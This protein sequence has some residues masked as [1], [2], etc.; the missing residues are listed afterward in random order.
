ML[1]TVDTPAIS[2]YNYKFDEIENVTSVSRKRDTPYVLDVKPFYTLLT[3]SMTNVAIIVKN[4]V[5]EI[6]N[7]PDNWDGC[8]AVAPYPQ[9]IKNSYKFID[10]LLSLGI[11]NIDSEDIYPMPY[12]SIVFEVNNNKG[13]VSIEIGKH[14]IGFFTDFVEHENLFSNGEETDFRSIPENL[15]KALRIL[16]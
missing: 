16:R 2:N 3:Q 11:S 10:A 12:G 9:V 5:S 8:N 14:S 4:R 13:M 7:L 6:D 15:Q 1:T